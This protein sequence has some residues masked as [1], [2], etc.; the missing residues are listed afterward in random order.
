MQL[1]HHLRDN[2][3]QLSYLSSFDSDGFSVQA[4]SSS[5]AIFN[6][7]S[8]NYVFMGVVS[9]RTPPTKTYKVVVVSDSGNKYRFRNSAIQLHLVQVQLL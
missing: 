4:G 6:T 2:N 3:Q 8:E 1:Y 7:N 5:T 9:R